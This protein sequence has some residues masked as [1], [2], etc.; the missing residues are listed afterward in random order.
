M[1]FKARITLKPLDMV[2]VLLLVWGAILIWGKIQ[3][4]LHYRWNWGLVPQYV[5]RYDPETDSWFANT[6]LKGLLTTLRLSVW[7]GLLATLLGTAA[8]LCR[9]SRSL[10]RRLIGIT[11]VGLIRNTP[12]LVLVFITYFFLSDQILPL[13]RLDNKVGSLS[14]ALQDT[15]AWVAAPAG[16]FPLF[17]AA[18]VTLAAYEG[19][20]IAEIIRAGIQ[21]VEVG[22]WEASSALG[23]SRR[24]QM[25]F[26]VLPQAFQRILP[27][28]AGQFISTI[29]DSAILS[30]ISV[31]EL[32]FRG[33][34]L[35]ASSYLTFE[36]WITITLMYFVLTFACSYLVGRMEGAMRRKPSW[37][38]R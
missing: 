30:V 22:Q 7:G 20:Y 10:F 2:L 17:V 1:S 6:L 4:N 14:P 5:L 34:E 28:L 11:Y 23:F 24:K 35:M 9:V 32:T 18:V 36:I 29:K 25:Q 3:G 21:S 26:V 15:L 8:G 38:G 19:A 13:L 27:P 16:R 33:Q 12:P 31:Q 37:V